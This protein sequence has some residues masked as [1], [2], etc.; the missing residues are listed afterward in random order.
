MTWKLLT[1]RVSTL[2]CPPKRGAAVIW[3]P[4]LELVYETTQT[5]SLGT[6]GTIFTN[7][8]QIYKINVWLAIKLKISMDWNLDYRAPNALYSSTASP[9]YGNTSTPTLAKS[10][11]FANTVPL[12]Q[13][14]RATSRGMWSGTT[15][16][17]IRNSNLDALCSH[18][19]MHLCRT[20][21]GIIRT[22]LCFFVSFS[23]VQ[24][25]VWKMKRKPRLWLNLISLD[26]LRNKPLYQQISGFYL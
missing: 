24:L 13:A 3:P 8:T 6:L 19:L 21:V 15:W 4:N 25:I 12:K 7:D 14:R 1:A 16:P 2:T 26:I 11:T 23:D 5:C 22:N 18:N 20:N 17:L 10:P 9:I